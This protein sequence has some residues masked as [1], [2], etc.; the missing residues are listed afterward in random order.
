MLVLENADAMRCAAERARVRGFEVEVEEGYT[1]GHYRD[2]AD[3]L[4]LKLVELHRRNPGRPVCLVSGGEVSC[5]VVGGGVGGRNQ[6]FVL[7]SAARLAKL[8]G[9]LSAAVLS[10]GT[11]GTDGNSNAAGA[12][13]HSGL[14]SAARAQELEISPFIQGH[15][16][17]SFFKQAGG[18]IITGP[19]GNNVRDLRIMLAQPLG[20]PC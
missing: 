11:D 1:E 10:C 3:A 5:P 19:T 17:H 16:S 12:V 8:E 14:A 13:A 4:I 15:D 6:E 2:V 7:Y 18:L 20:Q 9:M